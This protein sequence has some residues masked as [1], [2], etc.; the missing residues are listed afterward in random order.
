MN[1]HFCSYVVN[2]ARDVVTV[3]LIFVNTYH[4]I[5]TFSR[6]HTEAHTKT[7]TH[8]YD[9]HTTGMATTR[10]RSLIG[11][12]SKRAVVR[13]KGLA[14]NKE[15]RICQEKSISRIQFFFGD[16]DLPAKLLDYFLRSDKSNINQCC[17]THIYVV[18]HLCCTVYM[19]CIWE[20]FGH[21]L[22]LPSV[23]GPG[24]GS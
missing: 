6:A 11:R 16:I 18:K 15:T 14:H 22:R 13:D 17:Y 8:M 5:N 24:P 12:G 7:S 1:I 3:L 2:V 9:Q 20:R 4:F 23:G 21:V 19:A 10:H